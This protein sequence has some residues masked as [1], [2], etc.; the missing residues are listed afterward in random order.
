MK[1]YKLQKL[2]LKYVKFMLILYKITRNIFPR[3]SKKLKSYI[4]NTS[5]KSVKEINKIASN[6]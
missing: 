5:L 3:L 6:I 1:K 4:E 2:K